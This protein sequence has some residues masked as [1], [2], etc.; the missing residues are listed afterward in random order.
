MPGLVD[1]HMHL[2][3]DA[4]GNMTPGSL[5]HEPQFEAESLRLV[6][7]E[8]H[9]QG[10]PVTAHAHSARSIA[11]SVAAGVDGIEHATFMNAGGV[12][13]PETLIRAIASQRIAVG[14]TVGVD[15]GRAGTLPPQI[16]SR[17]PALAATR[18]RLRETGA[19]LVADSDAGV[20]PAKPHDVLPHGAEDLAAAGLSPA[21]ILQAMTSRAAQACGLGQRK[22]R[23]APGFDADLIAVDGNP[24]DDP[25]VIRRLRAVYA[26]G[27]AV[28]SPLGSQ[29][30]IE[31]P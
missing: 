26:G 30:R 15:P 11:D 20:T 23:I 25:T 2:C 14:W 12:D 27:Q 22:G 17:M 21:E 16:A 10:L 18:R 19:L 3:F 29:P 1:T 6:A 9:R 31:V 28:R 24:L 13:A 4:C 7:D 8:A 5:A